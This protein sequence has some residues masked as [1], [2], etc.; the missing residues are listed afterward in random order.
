MAL[1]RAPGIGPARFARLLEYFGSAAAVFAVGRAE[2]SRLE[3]PG[4][5]LDYLSAPDWRRVETDLAWLDQPDNHL[6]ALADPRYPLLLR[7]I[8]YPPPLLFVHGDPDCLRM[9]QLAIV[10]T[11][12]PTPPGRETAHR[13]A[14][15]LAEAGMIITSGLALGIDTAAHEG[16]LASSKGRTIAVMGT[17]LDRVYPAKNRDLAHKI[18]ER[19]ALVSELPTG[20]PAAAGNFPQR[21]RLI[22]GLTLGVLVVEAAARS[23]S[24]ITARL[25]L[26]QGREVFAIP[27][28]IHNPLAKGCHALIREG[29]KLVEVAT[30]I[31][32]ELGSLAATTGSVE[33]PVE[34]VQGVAS[35][36]LDSLDEMYRQLL[37]AMGD[38]PCGIDLLV[39]RCGLTAEV[40]SSMLLILEL[41]GFTAAVPGGFYCR[42]KC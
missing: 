31:L 3:L 5:A 30:D 11:R 7:Q 13:F 8:P 23:G 39:E 26:E 14:E 16:A 22:S 19:G 40:V 4:V 24:L 29:A 28:S 35:A 42:L 33:S 38:E 20:T 2:W 9:L 32:E 37:V 34:A 25:A 36:G 17:S 15:H 41:E 6:L 27:G 18:A 12:N 1:L 10:G 21:N